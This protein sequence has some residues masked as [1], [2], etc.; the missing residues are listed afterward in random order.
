MGHAGKGGPSKNTGS[1]TRNVHSPPRLGQG[2]LTI[3]VDRVY[4]HPQR[5]KT[6]LGSLLS[7]NCQLSEELGDNFVKVVNAGSA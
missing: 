1:L 3:Q 7:L 2:G 6:A 4:N 5:N